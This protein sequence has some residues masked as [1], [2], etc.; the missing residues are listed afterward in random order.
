MAGE[1]ALKVARKELKS[2]RSK[3]RIMEKE[4]DRHHTNYQNMRIN[5][6]NLEREKSARAKE[7]KNLKEAL[8][9]AK[10]KYAALEKEKENIVTKLKK[11]EAEARE[12]DAHLWKRQ[13][14]FEQKVAVEQY[15]KKEKKEK[16]ER[17]KK[18]KED[19][20]H[21]LS[22][23]IQGDGCFH[24]PDSSSDVSNLVL[25]QSCASGST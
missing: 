8:A 20:F 24:F 21:K 13:I 2:S 12:V 14:D 3:L 16:E 22:S 19:R 25:L 7:L 9:E 6:N 23:C 4:R 18:E 11:M 1:K 15:K 5:K 10:K 17:K